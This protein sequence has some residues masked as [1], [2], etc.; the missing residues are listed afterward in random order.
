MNNQQINPKSIL[1]SM[2]N[3][4]RTMENP[5]AASI[6]NSYKNGDSKKLSELTDN[7]FQEY[8]T[9]ADNMKKQYSQQF[10]LH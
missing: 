4:R 1:L 9:S 8:G 6:L 7:V 10:G 5:T 2:M 3:D